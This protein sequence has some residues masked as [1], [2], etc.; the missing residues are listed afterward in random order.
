MMNIV[1]KE[2]KARERACASIA[3]PNAQE[4][5]NP[6]RKLTAAVLVATN[7]PLR[8]YYCEEQHKS[9]SCRNVTHPDSWKQILRRT[10][11]C[12]VC[13]RNGHLSKNCMSTQ[14][15]T[16]CHGKHHVTI[17]IG[18]DQTG[19]PSTTDVCPLDVN[20]KMPVLLQT[21]VT[22][23]HGKGGTAGLIRTRLHDT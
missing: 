15:C 14:R 11:R 2:V 10:G 6:S 22:T 12:F 21:A 5:K 18:V 19:P 9:L 7:L 17:C 13:V 23:V 16:R 3:A 4:G 20:M 1:G 8:C